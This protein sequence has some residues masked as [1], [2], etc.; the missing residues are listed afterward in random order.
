VNYN[1]LLKAFNP[2]TGALIWSKQMPGQSAFS[3]APTYSNGFVYLGGAGSGGTVYAVNAKNGTVVWT[4]SVTNGDHSSPAVS[5]QAVYVSYACNQAY[6]F[7]A[8]TGQLIWHHNPGCSGGGGKTTVLSNYGLFTRDFNGN[9]MLD[10]T[11]GKTLLQYPS[12]VAPAFSGQYRLTLN[13]GTLNAYNL[14]TLSSLWS[15]TTGDG[16][17]SSAPI[18]VNNKVF[19]GGTSGMLYALDVI[20]GRINWSENVGAGISSPDEQNVSQPLTGLAAGDD[21]ILIPAGGMLIAYGNKI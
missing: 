18:I 10:K 13:N 4:Q 17:L 3:S 20:T 9:L 8:M 14:E 11:T 5:D 12:N 1:G 7:S 6:K 15:F 21:I 19:V 16:T 2:S